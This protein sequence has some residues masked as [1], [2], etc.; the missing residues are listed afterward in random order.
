MDFSEDWVI[1]ELQE[2]RLVLGL[3]KGYITLG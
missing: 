1:G 3:T 2:A